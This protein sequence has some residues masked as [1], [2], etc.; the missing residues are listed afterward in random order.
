MRQFADIVIA[1]VVLGVLLVLGVEGC[2][3]SPGIIVTVV[4]FA[5]AFVVARVRF[6]RHRASLQRWFGESEPTSVKRPV[7]PWR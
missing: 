4:F 2:T 3:E 1:C 5:G 7:E 6:R